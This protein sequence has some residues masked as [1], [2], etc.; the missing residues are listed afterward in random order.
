MQSDSPSASPKYDPSVPPKEGAC[1]FFSIPQELRDEIYKYALTYNFGLVV[2]LSDEGPNGVQA[3]LNEAE[4]RPT[5]YSGYNRLREASCHRNN[6]SLN[7]LRLVSRQLYNETVRLQF[8]LNHVSFISGDSPE[9]LAGFSLLVE[10]CLSSWAPH[11][12]SVSVHSWIWPTEALRVITSSSLARLCDQNPHIMLTLHLEH[13]D[14]PRVNLNQKMYFPMA[15]RIHKFIQRSQFDQLGEVFARFCEDWGGVLY[16]LL[17]MY[18]SISKSSRPLEEL[19]ERI[20]AG[21]R[22]MTPV[23]KSRIL[24]KWE[25]N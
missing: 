20:S 24:L 18:L 14:F 21:I 4:F 15:Y 1:V 19:Q 8:K 6:E 23:M 22:S 10:R 17:H 11:V 12:R 25:S 13:L 16:Q 5:T 9:T 2:V 3:V 7:A